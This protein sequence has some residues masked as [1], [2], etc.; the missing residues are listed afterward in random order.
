MTMDQ[1][2]PFHTLFNEHRKSDIQGLLPLGR[3][4]VDRW[5]STGAT[6]SEL[7]NTKI[8]LEPLS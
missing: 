1:P 4:F 6:H 8:V 5:L 2:P 3:W 7:Y